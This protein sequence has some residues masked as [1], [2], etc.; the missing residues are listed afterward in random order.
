MDREFK[1]TVDG[2]VYQIELHGNSLLVD[3][4]P[5]V[6]GHENGALTVNGIIYDVV[7]GDKTAAV[8]DREYEIDVA[9]MAMRA[10]APKKAAP[11]KAKAAAGAGSVTAIMP[12]AILK[13]L[14]AEGDQVGEGDVV[15]ILEAMKMENEIRAPLNGLLEKVYVVPGQR[16]SHDEVLVRIV[17]PDG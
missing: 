2:K 5:F 14:V 17:S 4:Q 7:L 15:V 16:V 3:G 9:G 10:T 12:G 11:K 6:I 13:V 1:L 8:D